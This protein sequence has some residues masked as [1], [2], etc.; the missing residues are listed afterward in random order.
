MADMLV[1][2]EELA[3][4]LQEDVDNATADLAI[5]IATGAVQA[6]A[7][8]RLVQVLNDSAVLDLDELDTGQFLYLPEGPVTAVASVTVGATAVADYVTQL[9]RGR[10]WRALAWRNSLIASNWQQCAPSTVTVVYSHGYAV[11]DQKLQLARGIALELAKTAYN[12]ADGT[13]AVLREQIDDYAVQY[14]QMATSVATVLDPNAPMARA[15]RA[16]YGR[17]RR[18]AHLIKA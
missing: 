1:T 12:A 18:S 14:A 2:R 17:P 13:G 16:E 5:Q 7:G 8:Q 15:L 4:L 9:S 6:A 11:G 3:S 10:L